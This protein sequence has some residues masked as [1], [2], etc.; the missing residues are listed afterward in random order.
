MKNKKQ[1]SRLKNDAFVCPHCLRLYGI[2][3]LLMGEE[4]FE[5]HLVYFHG[6]DKKNYND[7]LI[8]L[9]RDK[10]NLLMEV[11]VYDR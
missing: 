1:I 5:R 6:Y 7:F 9:V 2:A 10:S 4:S 11:S 3:T 8:N